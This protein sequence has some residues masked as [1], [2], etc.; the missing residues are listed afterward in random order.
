M[1]K[2]LKF[3]GAVIVLF[4]VFTVGIL[5]GRSMLP[6]ADQQTVDA[7]I[8]QTV[9]AWPIP[10]DVPTYTPLPTYTAQPTSAPLIITVERI[11]ERE[12]IITVAPP[13][14]THTPEPSV[15]ST[16]EPLHVCGRQDGRRWGLSPQDSRRR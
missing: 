4:V 9:A 12:R 1:G 13:S 5:A 16:V 15:T 8:E 2:L 10:T 14:P 6:P 7:A 3:V 11:V